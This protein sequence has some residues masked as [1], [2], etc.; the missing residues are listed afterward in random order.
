MLTPGRKYL[1]SNVRGG[2]HFEH[3]A[4]LTFHNMD[5]ISWFYSLETSYL[6]ILSCVILR[7]IVKLVARIERLLWCSPIAIPTVEIV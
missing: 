4:K 3:I 5:I 1:E 6:L 2:D 7:K